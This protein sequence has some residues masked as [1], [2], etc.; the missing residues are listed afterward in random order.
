MAKLEKKVKDNPKLEQRLLKDGRISLYLEYYFGYKREPVKDEFG[1]PVLYESGT[2]AGT[3]KYKVVHNRQKENLNLYL[4]AKPKSPIDRENNRKAI[5]L[6]ERIRFERQQQLLQQEKGYR[7]E[8]QQKVD[9]LQF[10]SAYLDEYK[11]KDIRAKQQAFQRFLD[12]L[13]DTPEYTRYDKSIKPQQITNT[14]IEDFIDYLQTRSKGEGARS[15]FKRFKTLFKACISKSKLPLEM[16]ERPFV[17]DD[18]HRLTITIDEDAI[19]KDFLSP[20]EARLLMETHYKG[21]N[22]QIRNAF[23]FCL[24][25]GMRFCDVKDLTF[26]NFDFANR[27]LTYDQNKTKGHSKHSSV[28]LP[29]TAAIYG[30]LGEQPED[31]G[32]DELVFS[33]PSH[34]MC[35]K[36]LRSWTKKAGINKHI[37]WHCA[38][39]SFGTNM[40][41]QKVNIRVVQ[42]LMGHSD[43]KYT[44]RYTRVTDDQKKEAMNSLSSLF[45]S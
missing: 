35:L 33:L 27:L 17:D 38:R 24:N 18:G 34:T 10:C 3:P 37:T 28:S 6:A 42:V 9:F 1:E 7:I 19:V 11:K 25:T 43:L 45:E 29:L 39:H 2:M 44:E 12:F 36:A 20:E 16:Y 40:A 32:K 22:P 15:I 30:L 26:G 41:A 8:T 23:I 4:I 13:H 31:R 21:E 14:M 5:E